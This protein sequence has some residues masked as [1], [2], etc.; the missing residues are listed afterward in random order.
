MSF[1]LG[2]PT[3]GQSLGVTKNPIQQNFTTIFN[4]F[5]TDHVNPNGT[6]GSPPGAHNWVQMQSNILANLPAT[7][8]SVWLIGNQLFNGTNQLFLRPPGN[9]QSG[10]N[11][12]Q[13]SGPYTEVLVGTSPNQ[14]IG[15]ISTPLIGGLFL[16]SATVPMTNF[17]A[18]L[19]SDVC[20]SAFPNQII[21]LTVTIIFTGSSPAVS[22]LVSTVS[23][24]GFS[25][26]T[27]ITCNI[28]FVAIGY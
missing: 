18:V 3:T 21:G 14:T 1:T 23:A 27:N 17:K 25:V 10:I 8:S 2:I 7:P 28:S 24:T 15:G 4:T 13:F 19:F 20:G 6:N 22:P 16:K 11:D 26:L 12:L 9:D 5:A